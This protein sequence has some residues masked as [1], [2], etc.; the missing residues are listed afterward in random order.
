MPD[1]DETVNPVPA[2]ARGEIEAIT[3]EF[4]ARHLFGGVPGPYTTSLDAIWPRVVRYQQAGWGGMLIFDGHTLSSS[5][6]ANIGTKHIACEESPALAVCK[7]LLMAGGAIPDESDP[8]GEDE[9]ESEG[10]PL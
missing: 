4:V 7:A 10:E 8:W 5:F 9:G 1:R 2:E 6:R 3:D